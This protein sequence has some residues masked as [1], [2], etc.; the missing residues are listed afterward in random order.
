MSGRVLTLHG[1]AAQVDPAR[2]CFRN[3][4]DQG[5]LRLYFGMVE[6]FV[7][8]RDALRGRGMALTI[9]DAI[10]GAADAALLA[11]EFGHAV[12]LFVNPGQVVSGDPYW[13]LVLNALLDGLDDT[14]RTLDGVRYLTATTADR[15]VIRRRIKTTIG[16][17]PRE[18]DRLEFVRRLAREWDVALLD[19]P[20]HFQT[21]DHEALVRLRD[22]GVDLQNHG[23]WH[24]EH[25]CLAPAE[26]TREI[27]DGR[28]W[29]ARELGVDAPYFAAPFGTALP[30]PE[31]AATCE[32]WFTLDESPP[33]SRGHGVFNREVLD[34]TPQGRVP[35]EGGIADTLRAWTTRVRRAVRP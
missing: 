15:E 1:T 22:A 20:P 23:W 4:T 31:A 16:E 32:V 25:G 21:L 3:M 7:P 27:R 10:R 24:T 18:P 11:R 14:P 29:L 13:F 8:L 33:G 9:D 12:T 34:V 2:F 30:A 26:S 19:L 17:M 35:G 6:P 28:A 5:G